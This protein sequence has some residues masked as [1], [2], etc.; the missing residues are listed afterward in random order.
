MPSPLDPIP[1]PVLYNPW[2]HHANWVAS[3][4]GALEPGAD[5]LPGLAAELVVVGTRLMDFYAGDLTAAGVAA[6]AVEVLHAEGVLAPDALATWLDAAG[7]YRLL[8][9]PID[10]SVW[11]IRLG[12]VGGRHVHLHPGRHAP[13]TLRVNA[14]TLKTAVLALASAKLDGAESADLAVVN[15]VRRDYLSLPPLPSLEGSPALARALAAIRGT[16]SAG[17]PSRS[18]GPA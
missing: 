11:A 6:W 18:S 1:A 15:R 5:A 16:G 3:R 14:A 13:Q 7:G 17:S 10:G 4:L 8:T 9:H 12:E 2:K